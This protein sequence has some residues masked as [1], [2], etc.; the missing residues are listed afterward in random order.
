MRPRGENTQGI[1]WDT[2]MQPTDTTL[3]LQRPLLELGLFT[4]LARVP[5]VV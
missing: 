4:D 5:A 3:M 1:T 2:P